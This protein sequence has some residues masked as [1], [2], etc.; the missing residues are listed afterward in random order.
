VDDV[1]IAHNRPGIGKGEANQAYTQSDSP[2]AEQ[3]AKSDVYDCLVQ[4]SDGRRNT[5][6]Y[7]E[8]AGADADL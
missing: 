6:L 3:G 5:G 2:G 4:Q 8:P 1:T 7:G